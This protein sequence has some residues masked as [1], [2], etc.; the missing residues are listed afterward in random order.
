MTTMVVNNHLEREKMVSSIAMVMTLVSFSML[1][2]TL[3][4]GYVAYRFTAE[5]WPPL[6]MQRAS[7][8]LPTIST[9][10][11][12]MSS[13]SYFLSENSFLQGKLK[14]FRAYYFFTLMLG[15]AF[16]VSQLFLWKNLKLIGIYVDST[17]FG[18][19]IYAFTWIHAAHVVGGILALLFL[20]PSIRGTRDGGKSQIWLQNVG[21][22]WHFLGIIWVI[23]YF[24][25]F[26]F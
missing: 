12:L 6:G 9:V 16:M 17:V 22:F 7:L 1:F 18:S 25:I 11:I 13:F 21:Q 15:L 3:M 26:V 8:G 4:L 14:A 23:I 10:I 19:I 2:A 20:I 24:G 5:V